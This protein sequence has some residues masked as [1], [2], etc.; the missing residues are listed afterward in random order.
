ML[1][2]K[3]ITKRLDEAGI[4]YNIEYPVSLWIVLEKFKYKGADYSLL[5]RFYDNE[6]KF[7]VRYYETVT[8]FVP[9]LYEIEKHLL[10]TDKRYLYIAD[11]F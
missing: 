5:I 10:S 1:K 3:E 4:K 9:D 8:K 11:L 6:H 7:F 2:Y